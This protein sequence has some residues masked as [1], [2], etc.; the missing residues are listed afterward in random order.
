MQKRGKRSLMLAAAVLILLISTAGF[1]WKSDKLERIFGGKDMVWGERANLAQAELSASF[2]DERRRL[3]NN[4]SPC[5]L[6]LCTDPFNYWWMAHAID[7]AVD[8]YVRTGDEGYKERI[9]EL[10]QGVT[11]RNAGVLPNAYYDDMAWMG[12]ALLRAYDAT[13]ETAYKEG[14]Q[15]L[16]E[17]IQGGWNDEMGGG[18][19]WRKEQLDY[20]NTPANAPSSL[21]AARLY[22]RFGDPEDLAWAKRIYEWE[23][24]T[25][26]DPDT[27]HVWDGINRLG[28]GQIDKGWEFTYNQGT[29]IGAGIELYELTKER[30]Y[31]DDAIRTAEDTAQRLT[32][33]ASGMLPAE[34]EGDAALF[35]GILVRYLGELVRADPSPDRWVDLLTANA[36]GMWERGRAEDRALFG[37]SWAQPPEP[38]VQLSADLS[39]VMLLEVMARLEQEGKLR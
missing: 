36:N 18:I 39:G 8:G 30:A 20:K 1:L 35:K 33:P 37:L 25:L 13:G 34:G 27:G 31:L 11:D 14:A 9:A 28:D 29:Y 16:W 3:Y 17:D 6:Q 23:K 19:A 4:A 22:A 26:V 15:V 12:L 21:L 5:L 10:L 38:V 24:K 2:W 7:L 32:N